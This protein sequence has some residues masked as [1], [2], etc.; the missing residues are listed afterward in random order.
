MAMSPVVSS[1]PRL[2]G[3]A[4][5]QEKLRNDILLKLAGGDCIVGLN[6]GALVTDR[7]C[8]VLGD[9]S[10]LPGRCCY[11]GSKHLQ[12]IVRKS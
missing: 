2:A 12:R 3:S 9:F 11:L 8:D 5:T 6:L 10:M 4:N 7:T 1:V